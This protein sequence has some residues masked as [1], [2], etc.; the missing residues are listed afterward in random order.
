VMKDLA[1]GWGVNYGQLGGAASPVLTPVSIGGSYVK[2][3]SAGLKT[4]YFVFYPGLAYAIGSNA[5]G[6]LGTGASADS[7]SPT[8]M[9]GGTQVLNVAGGQNGGELLLQ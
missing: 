1:V 2:T 5:S 7:S 9:S 3:L 8:Q 4:A 6:A